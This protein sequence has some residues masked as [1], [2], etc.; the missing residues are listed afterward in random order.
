MTQKGIWEASPSDRV[1]PPSDCVMGTGAGESVSDSPWFVN[2]YAQAE[3]KRLY[4]AKL[5]PEIQPLCSAPE[6]S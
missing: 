5:P 6:D 4:H 3:L 2:S 1:L